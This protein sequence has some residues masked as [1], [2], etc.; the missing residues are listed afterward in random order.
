[1]R[2]LRFREGERL[3]QGH[4]A[5]QAEPGLKPRSVRLPG[6]CRSHPAQS[7]SS[8][9]WRGAPVPES[10]SGLGAPVPSLPCGVLTSVWENSC[11]WMVAGCGHW[12]W[13]SGSQLL[14]EALEGSEQPAV[15][16]SSG[17]PAWE[18]GGQDALLGPAVFSVTG[19]SS[20]GDCYASVVGL[21]PGGSTK[22]E[23]EKNGYQGLTDLLDCG[24]QAKA[25]S[26][27]GPWGLWTEKPCSATC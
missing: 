26:T 15:S 27:L 8:P 23:R 7:H 16:S 13:Q 19:Q 12:V 11:S 14:G 1:M 10:C 4:R 17:E 18:L 5:K 20:P 2:E 21:V 9:G 25:E 6:L 22:E 24:Q 3:P